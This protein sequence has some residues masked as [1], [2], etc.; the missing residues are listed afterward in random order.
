[1][2]IKTS[3]QQFESPITHMQALQYPLIGI[4]TAHNEIYLYNTQKKTSE[5]ILRLNIPENSDLLA[6]FDPNTLSFIFGT[7]QSEILN[8]IDLQQKKI[9]NRFELDQQNPTSL[10]FSED[11]LYFVCGTNQGRVLLW[12]CDSTALISRLHSYPEYN[13]LYIR[14]KVNFVSALTFRGNLFASSGYGGSIV[15]TDFRSQI[16]TKRYHP[17]RI[18]NTSLLFYRETLLVGNKSGTLLKIDPRGKL[19]NKRLSTSMNTIKHLLKIAHEPYILAVGEKSYG[20][21]INAD[22]MEILDDHYIETNHPITAV[23]KDQDEKLYVSTSSG[24]LF[25]FDLFPFHQLEVLVESRAY[26]KAY[27]Y[28][29]QEPLLKESEIYHRLEALFQNTLEKSKPLL[30]K[31]EIEQAKAILQPFNTVKSREIAVVLAAFSQMKKL[32]YLYEHKKFS[33][34]Y[35]L[36]EQFPLL[37]GSALYQKVEAQWSEKFKKAQKLM[38]LEKKKEAHEELLPFATVNAKRPFII[39]LIQHTDIFKMYSKAIY[40]RDYK[41]LNQLT[42]RYAILRKLPSYHDLIEASGELIGGVTEALK[43]EKF[44]YA[45][46]LLK[47]LSSIPQREKEFLELKALVSNAFNLHHAIEHKHWRSAYNLIDSYSELLIFPWAQEIET[48]WQGR[49]DVCEEYAMKGDALSIKKEF[50]NLINLPGRNERIGDLL[51]SA[52]HVQLKEAINSDPES[53]PI[54]VR[55]YCDLFG[56]DTEIRHLLRLAKRKHITPQL[57]SSLLYPKKRDQWIYHVTE[58]RSRITGL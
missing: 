30:E 23:C 57:D 31:G 15:L 49:L 38:L 32:F 2:P 3:L 45:H 8:I 14:P 40:E 20:A 56:M 22:T 28:C 51:R 43:T 29:D 1:M 17:S 10:M 44:E 39:L 33:P 52:Y 53:F 9:I 34:F 55:N 16:Q 36:V 50:M 6:A 54:G 5:K 12:R 19:P 37:E 25:Q 41:Q 24:E 47:E 7:N 46:L 42:S 48:L 21:L 13:S 58:L 4:V 26:A 18:E 35:G 27:A 11:G